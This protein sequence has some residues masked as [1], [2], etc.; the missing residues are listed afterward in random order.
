MTFSQGTPW[1][2]KCQH[3]VS[4]SCV[5]ACVTGSLVRQEGKAGVLHHPETCVGCGSC[6]LACP[7]GAL[8]YDEQEERMFKCNLCSEEEVPPCVRACDSKALVY[9]E[10]SLLAWD[11]KKT[12]AKEWGR[13][14]EGD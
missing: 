2:R 5:E 12:F 7:L 11:K 10:P 6:F 8:G 3:C 4:A 14:H 1:P 9:R 13:I